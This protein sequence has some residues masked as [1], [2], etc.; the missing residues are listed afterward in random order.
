[1]AEIPL[2]FYSNEDLDKPF[3]LKTG[4][5][6]ANAVVYPLAGKTI[7]GKVVEGDGDSSFDMDSS[8]STGIEITDAPNGKFSIKLAFDDLPSNDPNMR[9]DLLLVDNVTQKARRLWGGP[10]I[11]P[12][13]LADHP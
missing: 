3:Q 13:G 11:K 4:T 2:T 1:M 9:Y 5:T 6:V 7:I 12:K 8:T 10:V